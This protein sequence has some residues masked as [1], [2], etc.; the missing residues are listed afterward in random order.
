M[1]I[2]ILVLENFPELSKNF[3]EVFGSDQEIFSGRAVEIDGGIG[4]AS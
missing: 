3:A 2:N 1:L 4:I